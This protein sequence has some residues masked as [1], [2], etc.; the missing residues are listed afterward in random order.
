MDESPRQASSKPQPSE[1]YRESLFCGLMMF[2]VDG[3]HSAI[4]YIKRSYPDFLHVMEV[5]IL[6]LES[7]S[8]GS[9][10]QT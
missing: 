7:V 6:G 9:V 1:L 2:G 3:K 8:K 4:S 5:A 10:K